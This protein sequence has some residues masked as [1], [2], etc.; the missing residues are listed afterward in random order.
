[1]INHLPSF[2]PLIFGITTLLTIWI[3]YL[4]SQRSTTV[5]LLLLAWITLQ[6]MVCL[7]GFYMV[8]DTIPPRAALLGA[9][10]VLCILLLF[11]TSKGRAFIDRLGLRLLV[12][13]HVVRVPVELVLFWLYT[14]GAVPQL[15][16]FE[17][18]NLDILSG[19]TAPLVYYL[20]FHRK[21][22]SNKVLLIWNVVCLALLLNI[23]INAVL[24]IPS[25]IQQQAFEQPNVAVLYFPFIWLPC[26]IVPLVLLSHLASI[27]RLLIYKNINS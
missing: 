15:M 21:A 8:T 20:Y 2:I 10:P 9:P 4:A 23:V 19:L 25:N 12:M 1:M 13:L 27:R 3:F 14:N 24:S 17:G 16:T 5:L 6:G 26:C 22:I 7:S 18:R 11:L